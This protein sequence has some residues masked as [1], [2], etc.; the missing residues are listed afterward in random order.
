MGGGGVSPLEGSN[1]PGGE[2]STPTEQKITRRISLND[3]FI[4]QILMNILL[5][6]V[7]V[8]YQPFNL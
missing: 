7:V 4:L 2:P 8:F 6:C 1:H 5:V 3:V